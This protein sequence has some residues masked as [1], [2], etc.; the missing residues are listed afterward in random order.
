MFSGLCY[1]AGQVFW[2]QL[3]TAVDRSQPEESPQGEIE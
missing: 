3:E 1:G 2:Q